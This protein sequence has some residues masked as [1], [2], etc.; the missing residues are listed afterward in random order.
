[1]SLIIRINEYPFI[2]KQLSRVV[3]KQFPDN[4]NCRWC[5]PNLVR[6]TTGSLGKELCHPGNDS[7]DRSI[8]FELRKQ[9]GLLLSGDLSSHCFI[10]NQRVSP[11][12][13]EYT[14][15]KAEKPTTSATD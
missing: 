15:D 1:M 3:H 10:H 6:R 2:L 11:G 9:R 7:N 4:S 13:P 14:A 5:C 12:L 8:P